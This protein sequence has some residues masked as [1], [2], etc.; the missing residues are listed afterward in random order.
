MT[1]RPGDRVGQAI[2]LS[3]TALALFDFMGLIIKHLS[4]RYGAA[5]LS[6]YRNVFG[7]IPALIALWSSGLWH[8]GG[9][10]LR[11]RQWKIAMSRGAY[12]ALAQFLFY[13]SLGTMAF[14][15]ATTITYS[16]AVFM[17]ALAV[18]ILGEKVGALRW[19]AVIMGFVGVLMVVGP[20]RDS[21]DW[22][23]IAPLGAAFLYALAGVSARLFDPDV[24]SPLVNLYS[25]IVATVGSV[26][27]ALF[28]GGFSPIRSAADLVMIVAMGGF[29]GSAV[30]CLVVSY[31]MT[32]Q[33]NL[34]PFSY[35]GIPMAF[36][37]GWVFFGEAPFGDLFP[38]AILIV[39]GG[40]LVIWR[41]RRIAR[42]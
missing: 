11:L 19:S 28:A 39:A 10:N 12:V 3:L 41:E 8:S 6:A 33:S 9:R 15:T 37:F 5:E 40:L 27:L 23:A 20:T 24:P 36:L 7:I 34:A 22:V 13:Y 29:G 14:A 38:G 18:P 25:V 32:E 31:R 21:F 1:A 16:N 35:F 30:L 4:P 26:G 17:T 2:L 42:R